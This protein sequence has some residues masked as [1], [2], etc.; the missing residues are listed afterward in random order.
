MFHPD[1]TI[2]RIEGEAEH[3]GA[4]QDEQHKRGQLGCAIQGLFQQVHLQAVFAFGQNQ[5]AQGTH[6]TAFC[7][8][9]HAQEDRA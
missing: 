3:S 8:C 9:G 4:N 1:V 5:C 7:G 6:R 2:G